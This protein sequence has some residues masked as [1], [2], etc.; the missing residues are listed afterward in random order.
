MS[1]T[2]ILLRG[3]ANEDPLA[4]VRAYEKHLPFR[5]RDGKEPPPSISPESE[6]MIRGAA[7]LLVARNP[8]LQLFECG[9]NYGKLAKLHKLSMNY[10]RGRYAFLRV[11]SPS[12][13]GSGIEI[14]FALEHVIASI[15]FWHAGGR[16]AAVFERLNTYLQCIRQQTGF[17]IYDPQINRVIGATENLDESLACYTQAVRRMPSPTSA[18]PKKKKASWMWGPSRKVKPG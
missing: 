15:P 16:A 13:E 1:Y 2:F 3:K 6:A 18:K 7:D 12:E 5:P 9:C 11:L 10:V 4:T 14:M 17:F 8:E